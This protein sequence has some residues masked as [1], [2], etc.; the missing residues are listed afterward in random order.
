MDI[1]PLLENLRAVSNDQLRAELEAQNLNISSKKFLTAFHCIASSHDLSRPDID[2]RGPPDVPK[3]SI[4]GGRLRASTIFM[5]FSAL[6]YMRSDHLERGLDEVPE[7]SPLRPFRDVYRSGSIKKG[8]DTLVQHIRNAVTHGSFELGEIP[9]ITFKD[10][11]WQATL[12]VEQLLELCEHVHRFYHEA[13]SDN[14]PRPSHWS[15]YGSVT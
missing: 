2:F 12:G 15:M 6:C 4:R 9:E 7:H 14:V 8:E 10:R 11:N 13:F 5:I 1:S 3:E